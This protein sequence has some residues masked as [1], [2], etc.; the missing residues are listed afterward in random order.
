MKLVAVE[1]IHEGVG[2]I[3]PGQDFCADDDLASKLLKSGKA[4]KQG[5]R[6]VW[7]N[8]YWPGSTVL[9]I[10]SGPSLTKEDCNFGEAWHRRNE[11]H[12][13]IVVN[14]SY[15]LARWADVL[16][17]C[18]GRW[19]NEFYHR[20]VSEFTGEL[21]TQ[22]KN[23]AMKFP[24]LKL[25]ESENGQG[26]NKRPGTI[27]QGSNGGYQAVGLAY[28]AGAAKIILLGFDMREDKGRQ[29]WHLD[30]PGR[31]HSFANFSIWIQHFRRLAVDF[32]KVPNFQVVNATRRSDLDCFP[33]VAL[34]E[35]LA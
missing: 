4:V 14:T 22:D 24:K 18:D 15:Q 2:T 11:D 16:Y 13:A 29:H 27:N 10:A 6:L 32:Q 34:E 26:L 23:A 21:W 33:K 30:H 20:V 12:R 7:A 9:V 5:E 28:L 1:P 19:W 25:I 8:L 31:L 35:A 3:M 17:A